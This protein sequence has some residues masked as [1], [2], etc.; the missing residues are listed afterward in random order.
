[1]ETGEYKLQLAVNFPNAFEPIYMVAY[2]N[3]D[4]FGHSMNGIFSGI[5]F[6][7]YSDIGQ[8][9][10]FLTQISIDN[11]ER[12][13]WI[14]TIFTVPK[15]AFNDVNVPNGFIT[16]DFK[17]PPVE[18]KNFMPRPDNLDGYK[19]R[20]QKL[21]TYP[22][23]YATFNPSK[24]I[25]R[26][27]DFENGNP[28]FKAYCDINPDPTI[29]IVPINYQGFHDTQNY[30]NT[31]SVSGYPII[32]WAVD[33]YNVWLAQNRKL[34]QLQLDQGESNLR[35]STV[36][37]VIDTAS[38][39]QNSMTGMV[40]SAYEGLQGNYVS[41]GLSAVNNLNQT[42]NRLANNFVDFLQNNKNFN[43]MIKNQLAV[44]EQ[45]RMF[46]DEVNMGSNNTSAIGYGFIDDNMFS[47]MTIKKE[48]AMIIDLYFD[49]Y[50]YQRN[51]LKIPNLNNRPNWNY[52]KTIDANIIGNIPQADLQTL[53]NMFDSGVT[54]WHNPNTFLD[55]TQNNR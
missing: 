33:T 55:Y 3:A 49:M 47:I 15:I 1:M 27:E 29:K 5:Q 48:F 54:L 17:A 20:N 28:H 46:P 2:N 25:Y 7:A 19:P 13:E 12:L 38:T 32:G 11:P 53:R 18:W 36:R 21:L 50:G 23:C 35:Y 42:T 45:H 6:L 31:G 40:G 26:F 52:V 22:Y 34:L 43:Y 44:M 4:D 41:A 24:N 30:L 14:Q 10:G 51:R 16:E 9:R 8:L 37:Q 39:I